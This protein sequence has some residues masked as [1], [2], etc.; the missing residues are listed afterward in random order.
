MALLEEARRQLDAE[1]YAYIR[2]MQPAPPLALSLNNDV[3]AAAATVASKVLASAADPAARAVPIKPP[4]S[5]EVGGGASDEPHASRTAKPPN[6]K[7]ARARLWE[8]IKKLQCATFVTTQVSSTDKDAA[9]ALRRRASKSACKT[10]ATIYPEASATAARHG[11]NPTGARGRAADADT[12]EDAAATRAGSRPSS[13][14][15]GLVR[16]ASTAT[17]A[18][19]AGTGRG[20]AAEHNTRA[21]LR[22]LNASLAFTQ[23]CLHYAATLA[24]AGLGSDAQS[25]FLQPIAHD[26]T[27]PY[28]SVLARCIE[29]QS[30][31]DG[32]PLQN[33]GNVSA[34]SAA[35]AAAT[36]AMRTPRRQH[37]S[38]GGGRGRED[39]KRTS[40]AGCSDNAGSSGARATAEDASVEEGVRVTDAL[41]VF[42]P[43]VPLPLAL[44]LHKCV[45]RYQ[46][47]SLYIQF[48]EI[49]KSD[50]YG[51][52]AGFATALEACACVEQLVALEQRVLRTPAFNAAS[53]LK[54]EEE[55]LK[56]DVGQA[57][58]AL[59]KTV[60]AIVV[61]GCR[62]V[63]LMAE[64]PMESPS[65]VPLVRNARTGGGEAAP[66]I[67]AVEDT[68]AP[69][70]F[71]MRQYVANMCQRLLAYL[72][73]T[74]AVATAA[75]DMT[76]SPPSV[77]H[78][79]NVA[80][81][82]V[83]R[84]IEALRTSL[85][86]S[87]LH[88]TDTRGP[89]AAA[90]NT[91]DE[92]LRGGGGDKT[93][94]PLATVEYLPWRLHEYSLLQT[95]YMHLQ[96]DPSSVP[97]AV[98]VAQ[99][100]L[101]QVLQLMELEYLD[102]VPPPAS[103]VYLLESAVQQCAGQLLVGIWRAAFIQDGSP[104]AMQ[105]AS[106]AEMVPKPAANGS[107]CESPRNLT[108]T[109]PTA[110]FIMASI[111]ALIQQT[112][113]HLLSVQ[114]SSPPAASAPSLVSL[115]PRA[116]QQRGQGSGNSTDSMNGTRLLVVLWTFI[117]QVQQQCM[118]LAGKSEAADALRAAATSGVQYDD[119]DT[120]GDGA[121]EAASGKGPVSQSARASSLPG[122]GLPAAKSAK[123]S[124]AS[125]SSGGAAASAKHK[126]GKEAVE[127]A[128]LSQEQAAAAT[129][130]AGES[131]LALPTSIA[132]PH[133][134]VVALA[135]RFPRMALELT[136]QLITTI[137]AA[138]ATPCYTGDTDRGNSS[139][140]SEAVAR[141]SMGTQWR[142]SK[143]DVGFGAK[144]GADRKSLKST[145]SRA[146]SMTSFS[147]AAAAAPISTGAGASALFAGVH[148]RTPHTMY[149]H[150]VETL[151][152]LLHGAAMAATE[153]APVGAE[154]SA[155]P[156]PWG[157]YG[158]GTRLG[159]LTH[160]AVLRDAM[161][162]LRFADG[163]DVVAAG[164]A[165]AVHGA[166]NGPWASTNT[167]VV[168]TPHVE[169]QTA[170]E[171]SLM[172]RCFLYNTVDARCL[173]RSLT[174]EALFLPPS[175]MAPGTAA[176]LAARGAREDVEDGVQRSVAAFRTLAM[177]SS[178]LAIVVRIGV[179]LESWWRSQRQQAATSA[180]LAAASTASSTAKGAISKKKK[181]NSATAPLLLPRSSTPET[182]SVAMEACIRCIELLRALALSVMIQRHQYRVAKDESALTATLLAFA[183][184]ERALS[185]ADAPTTSTNP[186][187]P[188]VQSPTEELAD[189]ARLYSLAQVGQRLSQLQRRCI[190]GDDRHVP[191]VGL[192]EFTESTGLSSVDTAAGSCSNSS[193]GAGGDS[194]SCT[195]APPQSLQLYRASAALLDKV[196]AALCA[197]PPP[198][199][200]SSV[201]GASESVASSGVTTMVAGGLRTPMMTA[202]SVLKPVVADVA[203]FLLRCGGEL[204]SQ[205]HRHRALRQLRQATTV[206]GDATRPN[207]S[208]ITADAPPSVDER[209]LDAEATYATVVLCV[210]TSMWRSGTSG[211]SGG[212]Q[213]PDDRGVASLV[214]SV[215]S[216]FLQLVPALPSSSATAGEAK[217]AAAVAETRVPPAQLVR[218]IAH[219][220][221]AR[222]LVD[223]VRG[224]LQRRVESLLAHAVPR[225]GIKGVGAPAAATAA[226]CEKSSNAGQLSTARDALTEL[227]SLWVAV[228]WQLA[229]LQA[230]RSGYIAQHM[231]LETLTVRQEQQQVYGRTTAKELRILRA[232]EQATPV[233]PVTAK[234]EE[235]RLRR[236]VAEQRQQQSQSRMAM[237]T[238]ASFLL[239]DALVCTA[240]VPLNTADPSAQQRLLDEA[241]RAMLQAEEEC[242]AKKPR[243]RSSNWRSALSSTRA[244]TAVAA[245][246]LVLYTPVLLWCYLAEACYVYGTREQAERVRAVLDA[247]MLK[248]M[249]VITNYTN[250][251]GAVTAV[252][253]SF[254]QRLILQPKWSTLQASSTTT[255]LAY[256][257]TLS[258]MA[259]VDTSKAASGSDALGSLQIVYRLV[260]AL[261]IQRMLGPSEA[262]GG[263]PEGTGRGTS[264]SST[265]RRDSLP[266]SFAAPAFASS[267]LAVDTAQQLVAAIL[268]YLTRSSGNTESRPTLKTA[269]APLLLPPLVALCE[270][271]LG[272][273]PSSPEWADAAVQLLAVRVLTLFKEQLTYVMSSTMTVAGA[274]ACLPAVAD[275][276][277]RLLWATLVH[278]WNNVL[279][280]PNARQ[281]RSLLAVARE[282]H[283]ARR[284]YDGH[285]RLMQQQEAA[286]GTLDAES[287]EKG[288]GGSGKNVRHAR[289]GSSEAA[290][291]AH[292]D[293][294][295]STAPVP[296]LDFPGVVY[297]A[298]EGAPDGGSRTQEVLEAKAEKGDGV[299][300]TA[301]AAP[302][303]LS[304]ASA[305]TGAAD[306]SKRSS[307]CE[308]STVPMHAS[309]PAD[310]VELL[311]EVLLHVPTLWPLIFSA[312]M[313]G[314]AVTDAD[315]GA[316]GSAHEAVGVMA[317]PKPLRRGKDSAEEAEQQQQQP[318][319][320][321]MDSLADFV[322]F[323]GQNATRV[324]RSQPAAPIAD[325]ALSSSASG[326][327]SS[328]LR[329]QGVPS[330]YAD[331]VVAL[332]Q[333]SAMITHGAAT[334]VTGA[335]ATRGGGGSRVHT[336]G[337]GGTASAVLLDVLGK[338][339][340]DPAYAKM[341][342]HTVREMLTMC[343]DAHDS[344]DNGSGVGG[345]AMSASA[346]TGTAARKRNTGTN[347][348]GAEVG[349][350]S[351]AARST[352]VAAAAAIISD[353]RLVMHAVREQVEQN[354]RS[355][356][357][358][359]E[360]VDSETRAWLARDWH[361][362]CSSP[363]HQVAAN[364]G[365]RESLPIAASARKRD[366][367]K[368]AASKRK[369]ANRGAAAKK[370]AGKSGAPRGNEGGHEDE[371]KSRHPADDEPSYTTVTRVWNF[372]E[373]HSLKRLTCAVAWWRRR[374]AART[375]RHRYTQYNMPFMAQM[376]L[377][378]A[379]LLHMGATAQYT[380]VTHERRVQELLRLVSGDGSGD[381]DPRT[382][383]A[384][385]RKLAVFNPTASAAAAATTQGGGAGSGSPEKLSNSINGTLADTPQDLAQTTV[386][387]LQHCARA[388]LLFQYL[389]LPTRASTAAQLAVRH[390][391]QL[392]VT[393]PQKGLSVSSAAAITALVN[394]LLE[395]PLFSIA[396]V[397][398]GY[399]DARRDVHAGVLQPTVVK[400]GADVSWRYRFRFHRSVPSLLSLVSLL[401]QHEEMQSVQEARLHVL[402][403]RQ[404]EE[405]QLRLCV[406]SE[407]TTRAE[408]ERD[409]L[410]AK[411][412]I[413]QQ[414]QELLPQ[415]RQSAAVKETLLAAAEL[416]TSVETGLDHLRS[417]RRSPQG[418]PDAP[419][420]VSVPSRESVHAA[421][422]EAAST[423]QY[424]TFESVP[425]GGCPAAT[426]DARGTMTM[427][428]SHKEASRCT[429]GQLSTCSGSG[430]GDA[431]GLGSVG[432][433]HYGR[434]MREAV[435]VEQLTCLAHV[436][437]SVQ[438]ARCEAAYRVAQRL[439]AGRYA[440]ELLPRILQIESE[441]LGQPR[442][443]T[444]AAYDQAI[445]DVPEVLVLL[446]AARTARAQL[447]A[448]EAQA[449]NTH[450]QQQLLQPN[451]VSAESLSAEAMPTRDPSASD[452]SSSWKAA[453]KQYQR[454][455][456]GLR[457]A[458]LIQ[459]LGECLY[460]EG[461]L[462]YAASHVS[463]AA[464]RWSDAVDCFLSTPHALEDWHRHRTVPP[465]PHGGRRSLEELLWITAAL[466]TLANHAFPTD[467][468]R[469]TDAT[470]LCALLIH[471]SW[472]LPGLVS[473]AA[474]S[475]GAGRTAVAR[476]HQPH[477]PPAQY[478]LLDVH[479]VSAS[480]SDAFRPTVVGVS[481][482]H[483][484]TGMP[485][486]LAEVTRRLISAAQSLLTKPSSAC[487]SSESAV[488]A[489]FSDFVATIVLQDVELTVEARLVRAAAAAHLG[490]FSVAMRH[491]YGVCIGV[492]LPQPV[493]A[494]L[495]A[496]ETLP[497][498][499]SLGC[500][501][502]SSAGATAAAAA[503]SLS[504]PLPSGS[505][506]APS[507]F[508]N[509]E[510]SPSSSHNT[511][512]VRA[513][514]AACLPGL[515]LDAVAK[516]NTTVGNSEAAVSALLPL[517]VGVLASAALEE[518][519][520]VCLTRRVQLAIAE[521]F[522][523]LG[524]CDSAFL[525]MAPPTVVAAAA[526]SSL[527]TATFS[528]A[529]S[530][531][532]G[533]GGG[534][535]RTSLGETMATPRVGSGGSRGS[536]PPPPL[537]PAAGRGDRPVNA[538]T[539]ACRYAS[540]L[541]QSLASA[542][543]CFILTGQ[544]SPS[545][546]MEGGGAAGVGATRPSGS[547]AAATASSSQASRARPGSSSH[548]AAAGAS[549]AVAAEPRTDVSRQVDSTDRGGGGSV[550]P[551]SPCAAWLGTLGAIRQYALLLTAELL[552]AQGHY[553]ACL[554]SLAA[555]IAEHNEVQQYKLCHPQRQ[556]SSSAPFPSHAISTTTHPPSRSQAPH[557]LLKG[558]GVQGGDQALAP[559]WFPYDHWVR[560]WLLMCRCYGHLRQYPQL[561]EAAGTQ[562]LS[563]CTAFGVAG[564]QKSD[565]SSI[566]K[567]ASCWTMFRLYR[568]YALMQMG[569]L[570]EADDVVE[571]LELG[572]CA[573]AAT[574]S[575]AAVT[576]DSPAMGIAE[577]RWVAAAALQWWRTH[578][579][580]TIKSAASRDALEQLV[581]W[582]ITEHGVLSWQPSACSS[583]S[584]ASTVASPPHQ[585]QHY[586]LVS[587]SARTI[588][589]SL[590]LS[591]CATTARLWRL[592][593]TMN[594]HAL[595]QQQLSMAAVATPAALGG[596][597]ASSDEARGSGRAPQQRLATPNC[598]RMSNSTS[599][600]MASTSLTAGVPATAPSGAAASLVQALEVVS[601]Q[602]ITSV[603][604][605]FW[606][607]SQLWA[608]QLKVQEVCAH[609][610][611][612]AREVEVEAV[613]RGG[614][615]GGAAT[616]GKSESACV[617]SQTG[618]PPLLL[619]KEDVLRALPA[620]VRN[621]CDELLRVLHCCV[622][623]P[624][625]RHSYVR[626]ILLDLTRV[627]STY[628]RLLRARQHH[629][630][631][632][633][634]TQSLSPATTAESSFVSQL[635]SIAAACA[636]LA[637]LVSDME[638]RV[639]TGADSL[640]GYATDPR[641]TAAASAISEANT[642]EQGQAPWPESLWAALQRTQDTV[643]RLA[644]AAHSDNAGGSG[645]TGL[646]DVLSNPFYNS[647]SIHPKQPPLGNG[648][649]SSAGSTG[650]ESD[651]GASAGR[652][653]RGSS[654]R[655]SGLSAPGT[656]PTM[657]ATVAAQLSVPT[658]ALT[659]TMLCNE[660]A[661]ARALTPVTDA[662]EHDIAQQL[663][664]RHLQRLTTPANCTYLCY[665]DKERQALLESVG[666]VLR[667]QQQQ[668]QQSSRRGGSS[669]HSRRVG[670]ASSSTNAATGAGGGGGSLP[671]V[672]FTE[673]DVWKALAPPVLL[674][675]VPTSLFSALGADALGAPLYNS[676][677]AAAVCVVAGAGAA[678]GAAAIVGRDTSDG[679]NASQVRNSSRGGAHEARWQLYLSVSP[680]QDAEVDAA[681]P[682]L[683]P[684]SVVASLENCALLPPSYIL[685]AVAASA[686]TSGAGAAA[687][688]TTTSASVS[689]TAASRAR[690]ASRQSTAGGSAGATSSHARCTGGSVVSGADRGTGG[691]W[692][693]PL[694][695]S[696]AT[697]TRE[698]LVPSTNWAL[699][700]S[701]QQCQLQQQQQRESSRQDT[702]GGVKLPPLPSLA[703]PAAPATRGVR[704]LGG[705]SS[706]SSVAALAAAAGG[707]GGGAS[708]AA[709]QHKNDG[710]APP[711]E[712]APLRWTCVSLEVSG[713]T[714]RTL[715]RHLRAVRACMW[716]VKAE[717]GTAGGAGED[718]SVRK[719]GYGCRRCTEDAVSGATG[720][721]AA[722][723][724]AV[725]AHG[726]KR[727]EDHSS[728]VASLA[729]GGNSV[730]SDSTND[731]AAAAR[732]ALAAAV[733][734]AQSALRSRVLAGGSGGGGVGGTAPGGNGAPPSVAQ[735]AAGDGG[736]RAG[737]NSSY[738][739]GSSSAG[740]AAATSPSTSAGRKTANKT[741][742][743]GR[744]VSRASSF[745]GHGNGVPAAGGTDG[746]Q[747]GIHV[748]HDLA[749]AARARQVAE[750]RRRLQQLE[751][752]LDE[753]KS[754][755]LMELLET[756]V[757]A[758]CASSLCPTAAEAML[759]EARIEAD[760][761][762]LLPR[763]ALSSDVIGFLEEWIG[764][765][766]VLNVQGK[767]VDHDTCGDGGNDA[768]GEDGC[769]GRSRTTS[770]R[771]YSPGLHEWMQRISRYV[772]EQQQQQQQR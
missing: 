616:R 330:I 74:S 736:A 206:H 388:A 565:N 585:L 514:L 652:G 461:G 744:N 344:L 150:C 35:S 741:N 705:R 230:H 192:R 620:P 601:P 481:Q 278:V 120:S 462:Y 541:L 355:M 207:A 687:A 432:A 50:V 415:L 356:E 727:R 516:H 301:S 229:R 410:Q 745:G 662:L 118:L 591:R 539:E 650:A 390:L 341:A 715:R 717:E 482:Q 351:I 283:W 80:S 234:D 217:A 309:A 182:R 360:T 608:A 485:G 459:P 694:I 264:G 613:V 88:Y 679:G 427:T 189:Y 568:L 769:S 164:A 492:G 162:T 272:L 750:R 34:V 342:V 157:S 527:A 198:P 468:P 641:V 47:L 529:P 714:V 364:A 704:K 458:G 119:G 588:L 216:G 428:G 692:W 551:G 113:A 559:F 614:G 156:S 690:I 212:M 490:S 33:S 21:S 195:S 196:T 92:R 354:R 472:R 208:A 54:R 496:E 347:T 291:G 667:Q 748:A 550:T 380:A 75:A 77:A 716:R 560:V 254:V 758:A 434:D 131:S 392:R 285:Q 586:V 279:R 358:Y 440:E 772:V 78:A 387:L 674:A 625:Q 486:A 160:A 168:G 333:Y 68:A 724:T 647:P 359:L 583:S 9:P 437:V 754:S 678:G 681:P 755:L 326:V 86:M 386:E 5:H 473:T 289:N 170:H 372:A 607:E 218:L 553:G 267:P 602:Y 729:V 626:A 339:K 28:E 600:D 557:A 676:V 697:S 706:F 587:P 345:G 526:S 186:L 209:E 235:A 393:L 503:T 402:R 599:T 60:D 467:S 643:G 699:L 522:V 225:S 269:A 423:I 96:Q 107:S 365:A 3:G 547:S 441:S 284:V 439:T 693:P 139:G 422:A 545:G 205:W 361:G 53:I 227:T 578:R 322:R 645:A 105:L 383:A 465:A 276:M 700:D 554:R 106:P 93:C 25:F 121:S 638:R 238:S 631:L 288:A 768:D 79:T 274:V 672:R 127:A 420:T 233:L 640:R 564:V 37:L 419:Q 488:L 299:T 596:G 580:K 124:K 509:D 464:K 621:V 194:L 102:P 191:E 456:Q 735:G 220:V 598:G 429:G 665:R 567:D 466:T 325:V 247:Q 418:L 184:V 675:A 71:A 129:A 493:L 405:L 749:D 391:Q 248:E 180:K 132:H 389:W 513:F 100:A 671:S 680:L 648:A 16:I 91:T 450:H 558:L 658:M 753:A 83:H 446:R 403:Q 95:C 713:S 61:A 683:L 143:T 471:Q 475:D 453:V 161:D 290:A 172:P 670:A 536:Q 181:L 737:F 762:R 158:S 10:Q 332:R 147:E 673:A 76:S 685:N 610:L 444:R 258:S 346:G 190:G 574:S 635:E 187:L 19:T 543:V 6:V 425:R 385:D 311:E 8:L 134:S 669:G 766:A 401:G 280:N 507:F 630:P 702:D 314:G 447:S 338:Y 224:Q 335:A 395:V 111:I 29:Q 660:A 691:A 203:S 770:L 412:D 13:P 250:D 476:T 307:A 533:G 730:D 116:T 417:R 411:V 367:G 336:G 148:I 313:D 577:D 176:A 262:H 201:D 101:H 757:S 611:A 407:A 323:A 72:S 497:G 743:S 666:A 449:T 328:L 87:E 445:R 357:A 200:S 654:K 397:Q 349:V 362:L 306:S 751:E 594:H 281:R 271:L 396:A 603:H 251:G 698:L 454:A 260:L 317:S 4:K 498:F 537:S 112:V 606:F 193:G 723:P 556:S 133:P 298:F 563:L 226:P 535:N 406:E 619:S 575:A 270:V 136:L 633:Q 46:A 255:Q 538:C 404:H 426:S 177:A 525:L 239:L 663:V 463:E 636:L 629:A 682:P 52:A 562:G 253:T 573:A 14:P 109:A 657:S 524:T 474:S 733:A 70:L 477:L 742:G 499:Y 110:S 126:L 505:A 213:L 483:S 436:V 661:A 185:G 122:G 179:A 331:V 114:C 141:S 398:H 214:R 236:W 469:A 261:Q 142:L 315:A 421:A 286:E 653:H 649:V 655:L 69:V 370:S 287:D 171:A 245:E 337:G 501:A 521:L 89:A 23:D 659:Y 709:L 764:S 42:A 720:T 504:S 760:V 731:H 480:F 582:A 41:D 58:D 99:R 515:P 677:A 487:Y 703:A 312:A 66:R 85:S 282:T 384:V 530:N 400:V 40:T 44:R 97:A 548:G 518:R 571:A 366:G 572:H 623:L 378:E 173:S 103:S 597:E 94:I 618:V 2:S 294:R 722:A 718:A 710:A 128:Q 242:A 324:L 159:A 460:E 561:E 175:L 166:A 137:E 634:G 48:G 491:V 249:P 327:Q 489:A 414:M 210:L 22:R 297:L 656:L 30:L 223:R 67:Y 399:Y 252:T 295:A 308:P 448:S 268:N 43:D 149:R 494:S 211:G 540:A 721:G 377:Y 152:V 369:L 615:D 595:E 241:I 204:R 701:I 479:H 711:C 430:G 12:V 433:T 438:P 519:Y 664:T 350:T 443:E 39:R 695:A 215:E 435:L 628:V 167:T 570:R 544:S 531:S 11:G 379:A 728:G 273:P 197:L 739:G 382:A 321:W 502:A 300:R 746:L 552:A 316:E 632:P 455:A 163:V 153:L 375:L 759:D 747:S 104:S 478:C 64:P 617:A 256:C 232:L 32:D 734:Q 302:A 726:A 534:Q 555:C 246:A 584:S 320:P 500:A 508:Y 639:R 304:P 178:Q 761:Q 686:E 622:E 668:P 240:L 511:A 17:S 624:V 202:L 24:Q 442:P 266:S 644:P 569:R 381:G 154:T 125:T 27:S 55:K 484:P 546:V 56:E 277:L 646:A 566:Y 719:N 303:H 51:D 707:G 123:K 452:T 771:F 549:E 244:A 684:G 451:L 45:L 732:C 144:D 431:A 343:S 319:Q 169:Q 199:T 368:A 352:S 155:P 340:D 510:E 416:L 296:S 221:T 98:A 627:V 752:E 756:I 612:G 49:M 394:Q 532:A 604:A 651:R 520:G 765:H 348:P 293:S 495:G 696:A 376:H 424:F 712:P 329:L 151:E 174:W 63:D 581:R 38:L 31:A 413:L 228:R 57:T 579:G 265:G 117:A 108:A 593:D 409:E 188:L 275:A 738:P 165:G 408:A 506:T 90:Q 590:A 310:L 708:N 470:L 59:P 592:H 740:S 73:S 135:A 145:R 689:G 609:L 318:Q 26:I 371:E 243:K 183:A 138:G 231:D 528:S 373:Q 81:A 589:P 353:A 374:R 576:A 237:A 20:N 363:Q 259:A 292:G 512:A 637:G 1:V 542:D 84:L 334:A 763:C 767:D 130:A 7:Q 219:G 688:M 62:L 146:A 65:S 140:G 257:R 725:E 642:E 457:A 82:V 517:T 523:R 115:P 36:A 305:A 263:G 222:R 605:S 18:T 15:H